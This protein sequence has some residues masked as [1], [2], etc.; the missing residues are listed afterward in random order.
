MKATIEPSTAAI[1]GL[2]A[3]IRETFRSFPLADLAKMI[4]G[5]RERYQVNFEATED[6]VSLYQCKEDNSTWLTREEAIKHLLNSETIGKY[7]SIQEVEVEAPTGNFSSIA[8]CGMSGEILGPPNHHEY[9]QNVARL[10]AERFSNMPIERFKSRIVMESGEEIVEKW[11]EKMSKR[12]EYRA[13]S[14]EEADEVVAEESSGD[15]PLDPAGG[16]GED[17]EAAESKEPSAKSDDGVENDSEEAVSPEEPAEGTAEEAEEATD[18]V[19]EDTTDEVTEEATD[20]VTEDANPEAEQEEEVAEADTEE[21]PEPD[22]ENEGIEEVETAAE[23]AA[24]EAK[25]DSLVLKSPEELARHFREHYAEEAVTETRTAVVPGNIQGRDLSRGLLVHLKKENEKLRR[26]FPL[27]LIQSLCREFE[28]EGL[29]FFK[30]GKKALH[31]SCVRPKGINESVSL[32]GPI[33]A[34]IDQILEKPGTKVM[35]LLVALADDF[36]APEKD[37]APESIELT[38]KA[39]SVLKDL[40]WLTSEGYVI[41]FPDTKLA[42]GKQ[43]QSSSQNKT[44]SKKKS[45]KPSSTKKTTRPDKVEKEKEN[46]PQAEE[47]QSSPLVED[48]T[49]EAGEPAQEESVPEAEAEAEAKKE[50]EPES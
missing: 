30:R 26:S 23:E 49:P 44:T 6:G 8:V 43:P 19:T 39:K 41:E 29:R 36:V 14:G 28:K 38:D 7:Y 42:L 47:E 21:T 1:Q 20:E 34:I 25:E 37:Q 22:E 31:V 33:Q 4:L 15:T 12:L 10:H 45:A 17:E 40:R 3:H 27:P 16:T 24:A 35:D 48:E 50:D 2:S 18:E 9:Q 32:T 5:A 13:K 46:S 11:K